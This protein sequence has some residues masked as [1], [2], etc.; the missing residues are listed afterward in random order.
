MTA[1]LESP[2]VER[3]TQPVPIPRAARRAQHRKSR[4]GLAMAA[5]VLAGISLLAVW[6]LSYALVITP[7][8]EHGDQHRLYSQFRELLTGNLLGVTAPVGGI[9]KA[10]SPV[11]VLSIPQLGLENA[12][13]VEGTSGPVMT[14]GPG[15]LRSTVFPGQP[16]ISAIFGRALTYGAP[17]GR[18]GRLRPGD[19]ITVTTGQGSFTFSVRDVRRAGDP[20]PPDVAVGA[21]RL[22]LVSAEGQGWLGRLA[23]TQVVFA[24]AD[25][26]GKT[27]DSPGGY[28]PSVP[29]SDAIWGVS[30]SVLTVLVFWL[31]LL[32]IVVLV[33]VWIVVR[34][35][36][37]QSWLVGVPVLLAVLIGGTGTAFGL[38]PNLL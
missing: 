26:V 7:L 37:R 20:M 14:S 10:G 18:L 8:A 3:V 31:Q 36:V 38:L 12:V 33:L 15:H 34:W 29:T 23:P 1:L 21:S 16:G 13:V 2:V 9:V 28:L 11:A 4:N 24:D 6:V 30:T 17:F 5:S 27:V 25:L 22:V 19:K 35:G 32:L